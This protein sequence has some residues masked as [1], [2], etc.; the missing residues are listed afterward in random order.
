MAI[1][2]R[3]RPQSARWGVL[4]CAV[5]ALITGM[6]ILPGQAARWGRAAA[7]LPTAGREEAAAPRGVPAPVLYPAQTYTFLAVQDDATTPVTYDPCR[8][9]HYVVRA[10]GEPRGGRELLTEAVAEISAQTGLQFVADG[11]TDEEPSAQRRSYQPL[12]YGDRWA[13]V[14]VAWR[15]A[16]ENPDFAT[17]VVGQARS[18]SVALKGTP[19]TY[20]T[21]QIWLDTTRIG[22][23]INDP[24]PQQRRL[25]RAVVQHELGHLV[26]LGHVDDPMQVMFPTAS[27]VITELGP[28]DRTGLARL[29]QGPC[30]PGL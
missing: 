27:P 15:T 22:A 1:A 8:P 5:G 6:V 21:G 13:P 24:D 10:A 4:A 3:P 30:V 29:G 28:G 25:A 16:S 26:G 23:M 9:V 7:G 17:D 2:G 19:R 12:R 20:V 18:V 14:L 11:S